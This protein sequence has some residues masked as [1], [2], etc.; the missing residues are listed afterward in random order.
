VRFQVHPLW[1]LA[2]GTAIGWSGL[3]Q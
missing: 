3:G 2:A 1:L